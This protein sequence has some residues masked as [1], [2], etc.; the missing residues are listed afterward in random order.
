MATAWQVRDVVAHL[1]DGDRRKLAGGRDGFGGEGRTASS[2]AAIVDI[3]TEQNASGVSYA[4]R[5]SPRLMTNLLETTG[6]WVSEYVAALAPHETSYV[7]V[8]WA[9]EERSENW[10]DTG[11]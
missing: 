11:R 5:L 7:A 6:R 9:A 3:I 2:Y 4:R 1:L 8:A 10:I